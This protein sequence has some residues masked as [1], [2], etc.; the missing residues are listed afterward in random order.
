MK[1]L[2]ISLLAFMVMQEVLCGEQV[3]RRKLRRKVIKS[4]PQEASE[5]ISEEEDIR[6]GRGYDFVVNE[7]HDQ[8]SCPT[9]R[10]FVFILHY[11]L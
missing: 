11:F 4:V 1:G 10:P 2:L 7:N 9:L 3:K 6:D 5:N 8:I